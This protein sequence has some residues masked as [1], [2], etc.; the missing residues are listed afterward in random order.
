M[1]VAAVVELR[2]IVQI[3][4]LRLDAKAPGVKGSAVGLDVVM[5]LNQ[6]PL[7]EIAVH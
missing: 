2:V 6:E 1:L 5:W 7:A 3:V 4:T